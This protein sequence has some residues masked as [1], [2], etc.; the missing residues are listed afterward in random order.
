MKPLDRKITPPEVFSQ[1]VISHPTA[2]Q[3]LI[4]DLML[5]LHPL[6][7]NEFTRKANEDRKSVV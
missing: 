6:D 5:E 7:V 2:R 4:L 3:R 1:A